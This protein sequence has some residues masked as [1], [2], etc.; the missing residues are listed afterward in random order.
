MLVFELKTY[1]SK[2]QQP[3]IDESIRTTQFI[4]NKALRKWIDA[5]KLNT[6]ETSK[7]L[8]HLSKTLAQEYDFVKPLNSSARQAATERAW[9]AILRFYRGQ[10]RFPKFQKDNRSVEF[11]QSGW[12]LSSDNKKINIKSY[13]IGDLKLKGTR[14][15]QDYPDSKINRVRIVKRA[16]GYY[17]QFCI[18]ADKKM[19][20]NPTGK[21][22]GIDMG[23][24]SFL[25]DSDNNVVDNPR[26]LR[27]SETQLKRLHRRHSKC[28][29]HS[30]N[31]NKA[32]IRL[33][34]KY[35]K[36]SRQRKD[37]AIK[38]ARQIITNSDFVA[39]ENLQIKNLVRNRKVAKSFSDAA[40]RI[41]RNW[42]EYF[43]KISR[44][45]VIAVPPQYTTQECSACGKIV[46]KALS[47]RTHI[48]SCGCVLGRDENAAINI[49]SKALRYFFGEY[50][51]SD[52]NRAGQ[53]RIQASGEEP[54]TLITQ[55]LVQ[56]FSLKEEPSG[57]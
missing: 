26:F 18:N 15:L 51:S 10:A 56:G 37:F 36:I 32:R 42:L 41:F 11:K 33:A 48:C 45:T 43:G 30:N 17:I 8:Y 24:K 53:A 20:H 21:A 54:S 19:D 49:L 47:E 31:R 5:P 6:K 22:I 57:T 2:T 39:I 40:F 28:K 52:K 3:L 38:L 9:N 44:V 1:P 46:Y 16:D 12:K 35:L 27:K 4:R 23:L 7:T 14:N 13:D 55:L 25:V 29:K 50:L 34:R